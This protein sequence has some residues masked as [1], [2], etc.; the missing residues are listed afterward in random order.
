M[1]VKSLKSRGFLQDVF[2]WN[3]S[4]YTVTNAGVQHLV[5]YLGVSAEVVPATFKKKRVAAQPKADGDDEK[6]AA[7]ET[8]KA[9]E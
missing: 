6:P 3:W 9:E 4:Y 1:V 5:E 2:S 7:D 8:P